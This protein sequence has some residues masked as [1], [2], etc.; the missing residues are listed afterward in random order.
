MPNME[1]IG[2]FLG[3]MNAFANAYAQCA[4]DQKW[5]AACATVAVTYMVVTSITKG[6]K[7]IAGALQ[8]GIGLAK[9]LGCIL[10][11]LIGPISIPAIPLVGLFNPITIPPSTQNFE[12]IQAGCFAADTRVLLADGTFKTIDQIKPGD[13][14][15]SGPGRGDLAAVAANYQRKENSW[16]EIH[17]VLPGQAQPVVVRTTDEHL[18]WE[19]GK[20]WVAA[21]ELK[22]GDWLLNQHRQR[23]QIT[24][25][26]RA[27]GARDVY[28]LKLLGDSAFYANGVLVHD[29]CGALPPPAPVR[30]DPALAQPPAARINLSK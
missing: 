24:A 19:D 2:D 1:V 29:L 27:S 25:N 9:Y 3:G 10:G 12:P 16:R 8:G 5:I 17:F 18:F 28:T 15:A 22:V 11:K 14:V 7:S 26:Q 30:S 20:G 6:A 21:A 4:K 13:V 23:V